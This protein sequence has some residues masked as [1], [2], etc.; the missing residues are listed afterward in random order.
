MALIIA[1]LLAFTLFLVSRAEISSKLGIN[2]GRVS[3]DIPSAYES[4]EIIKSLNAGRVKLYDANPEILKLLAGTKLKVSIMVQNHEIIGIAMNHTLAD[5]WV[6]NNVFPYI[7]QT[8][9]RY[10]LVGNEVL[11]SNSEYDRSIWINLV[12]AM[13]A[14]KTSLK[15]HNISN[16]KVGTP[17]AMDALQTTFPPSSASFRPE[18]NQSVMVPLLQFLNHTKSYF[19]IDVYP[20]FPWSEN[21]SNITLDFALF[22]SNTSYTDPATGLVYNNLL[23]QMLDSV[24]FAMAKLGYPNIPLAIAET[25]WP[26]AGDID[27][28]GANLHNAAIYNRNLIKKITAK[29]ALGTPARPGRVIPTFIFSLFNENQKTGPGTERHWGIVH[30]NGE[31][32]YEIDLA[33]K[34]SELDYAP[35]PA[36]YN[37]V[38]Y[39]GK[40]WC[41]VSGHARVE[42]LGA[43]LNFVCGQGNGTCDAL[44]PGKACYEPISVY[45]HAS[46][47]FSS[48]WSQFRNKGAT[49]YF[50]GLARQTM[51]NPSRR[52]CE[53][54]SVTL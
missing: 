2:Y 39:K 6:L 43:V 3:D 38:P 54:P 24:N 37:N 13:H 17:L 26:N 33:G 46:Y 23:D 42:D 49:C 16:I 40:L 9:I 8:V 41:V 45:D 4:I 30:P 51:I 27:Q 1:L 15:A 12:P 5:Q 28:I 35:L 10:I 21:S 34:R 14:I 32:V 50:N 25:G 18:I 36:A 11:S 29:P 53:F 31:P 20:Y 48:Y 7:P 22:T 52:S 47:A 44:T 19:F